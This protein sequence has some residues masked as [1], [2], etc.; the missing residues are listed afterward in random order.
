MVFA[1]IASGCSQTTVKARN[2]LALARPM[3][4][5]SYRDWTAIEDRHRIQPDPRNRSG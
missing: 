2:R 3:Q 5:V 4:L 1:G